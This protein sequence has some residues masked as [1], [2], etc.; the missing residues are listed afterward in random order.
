MVLNFV[1]SFSLNSQL[2]SLVS[3]SSFEQ[4]YILMFISC[5]STTISSH[6]EFS[7]SASCLVNLPLWVLQCPRCLL[8]THA[9]V[10]P[11]Q[12]HCPPGSPILS[13]PHLTQEQSTTTT[14]HC[15]AK[16]PQCLCSHVGQ[17]LSSVC[18]QYSLSLSIPPT[19]LSAYQKEKK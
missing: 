8:F 12:H 4:L 9:C 6:L 13:F 7:T 16:L 19:H 11:C 1:I 2:V 10:C 14:H 15:A 17:L 18:S 3:A 5:T